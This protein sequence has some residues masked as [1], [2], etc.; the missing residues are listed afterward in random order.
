MPPGRHRASFD[1]VLEFDRG[2]KV[3]CRDCGLLFREIGQHVG[4][5]QANV[6]GIRHRWMQ[7]ET[8]DRRDQSPTPRCTNAHDD[9]RIGRIDVMGLIVT[10]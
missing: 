6:I 5:N 7:E 1:Q 4:R 2:R 8:T 9:R 3:A 10:S